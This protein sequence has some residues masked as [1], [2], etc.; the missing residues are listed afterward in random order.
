M[1]RSLLNTALLSL[2]GLLLCSCGNTNLNGTVSIPVENGTLNLTPLNDNSIR[3]RLAGSEDLELKELI[4]TEKTKRVAYIVKDNDDETQ[5]KT[6]A[7][8]AIYDK[9]SG[10]LSFTDKDGNLLLSEVPGTRSISDTE[11][12]G[13]KAYAVSQSFDSPADEF[14]YG[15]GQF[16]DGYLNVRG[17]SRRLTQVNTQIALPFVLSNKGYG[18]L[19][20]NYGLTEFNPGDQKVELEQAEA[21]SSSATVNATGTSG[22]RRELRFYNS[23]TA[24]IDIPED[25]QY[26]LLLDVGQKMARKQY[27]AVDGEAVI[28]MSNLWLPPT[29]STIVSLTAGTH[30]LEVQGVRGDSPSVIWRK[31]TDQTTFA[32]PVAQ[33]IDYTVFAGSADE[34]IASYRKLTGEVPQMPDWMFSYVHCRER[35]HS[36][37]EILETASEFKNRQIPLGVIV[38]DWQWWGNTGWNSMVFDPENYADP[39]ALTDG[40]HEMDTRLM[41]SVWSKIDKSTALGGKMTE[42]GYYIPE[43]DWI[44]FLNPEAASFYWQNFRDSLVTPYGIDVWWLDAT[45]PENDDLDGRMVDNGRVPGAFYRN[46]YPTSVVGT[47]YNGMR[48]DCRDRV[49]VILTRSA[50]PG[51]QR[52]GAVTWSGDVGN[53]YKTLRYQIAGGLGQ[54]AAGLPWWTYDAGGFFRPNDQYTSTEYQERML[55]W[56]ETSVFLPF[57]RVHGYMSNTEPWNYSDETY[58][59]F[60]NCIKL[61]EAL[62]PYIT[63]VAKAVSKDGYTMMRPLVFDFPQDVE[64]LKQDCEYM[65]GPSLLICPVTEPDVTEWKCYLPNNSEGWKCMLDGKTYEGGQYVTVSVGP[66]MIPVFAVKDKASEFTAAFAR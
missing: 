36:Q 53:D 9:A 29:G 5:V 54:M 19:W 11:V 20:N 58:E 14:L 27:L 43:T 37:D 59:I 2:T 18:I 15:T 26:C 66:E 45:E 62:K 64:A 10:K 17:L 24:S 34:V 21:P 6:K 42:N 35:F 48:K 55:R 28:D 23:F 56:I 13:Y 30:E 52:Y 7:I 8:T 3:V 12:L 65:F 49:P 33:G 50:F 16:Q 46:A 32:S 57:M 63:E 4:Y 41:L 61:R 38:Q 22:N 60:V 44:D 1:R 40:L 39:K 25:G 51:M 31:V 47:V